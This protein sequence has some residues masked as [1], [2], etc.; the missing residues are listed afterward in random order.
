MRSRRLNLLQS[1][2][3]FNSNRGSEPAPSYLRTVIPNFSTL[4]YP[5]CSE[6]NQLDRQFVPFKEVLDAHQNLS[7]VLLL[8]LPSQLRGIARQHQRDKQLLLLHRSFHRAGQS[9]KTWLTVGIDNHESL[10][11]QHSTQMYE[12]AMRS[13]LYKMQDNLRWKS[14]R[15]PPDGADIRLGDLC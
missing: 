6:H 9:I 8:P 7:L 14:R 4:D 10:L 5:P 2:E 1:V 15:F 13:R 12:D 11:P 3:H